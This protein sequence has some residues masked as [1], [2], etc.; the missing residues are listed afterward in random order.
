MEAEL[1]S[2]RTSID[3][4]ENTLKKHGCDPAK[5]FDQPDV[6][7][8]PKWMILRKKR[9]RQVSSDNDSTSTTST[10]R[11]K[12][13]V[14]RTFKS[15]LQLQAA[16]FNRVLL[17]NPLLLL[18]LCNS[19]K[20]FKNLKQLLSISI[21]F[22]EERRR[23]KTILHHTGLRCQKSRAHCLKKPLSSRS[24][25]PSSNLNRYTIFAQCPRPSPNS[26]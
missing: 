12:K 2:L 4:I 6:S 16:S 17:Q 24:Y 23:L 20:Y 5:E 25:S 19:L 3:L 22:S 26:W 7:S 10:S 14:A 21:F 9:F 18:V 8:S 1:H 11:N 13:I 15:Q